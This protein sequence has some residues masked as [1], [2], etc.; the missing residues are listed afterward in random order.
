M[1]K[2]TDGPARG[3]WGKSLTA[4]GPRVEIDML[5]EPT[6]EQFRFPSWRSRC[7]RWDGRQSR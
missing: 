4:P 1:G 2:A 6:G 5:A 7:T 3:W